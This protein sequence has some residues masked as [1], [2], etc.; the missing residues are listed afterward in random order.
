MKLLAISDLHVRHKANRE[1][2]LSMGAR[3]ED[4]LLLVERADA[5]RSDG[6]PAAG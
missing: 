2:V 6:A 3:P 1:A 4:W 5:D